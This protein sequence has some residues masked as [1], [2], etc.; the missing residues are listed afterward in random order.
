MALHSA[1]KN[2]EGNDFSRVE[3]ESANPY[4]SRCFEDSTV[5]ADDF[6]KV[7]LEV[8]GPLIDH[9]EQIELRL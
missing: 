6:K 1:K 9:L 8:Y 2:W 4:I 3:P 7:A 5:L